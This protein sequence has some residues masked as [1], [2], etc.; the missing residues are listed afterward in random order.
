MCAST[1]HLYI[2]FLNQ[3]CIAPMMQCFSTVS[4][5]S[6]LQQSAE[7][8]IARGKYTANGYFAISIDI[9]R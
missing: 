9:C 1:Q 6:V 5:S 4:F 7:H 3:Q 8:V 2:I